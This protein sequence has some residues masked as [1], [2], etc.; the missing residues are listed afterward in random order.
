M[1]VIMVQVS[2]VFVR[3]LLTKSSTLPAVSISKCTHVTVLLK[4]GL[5][6]TTENPCFGVPNLTRDTPSL[7]S[8]HCLKFQNAHVFGGDNKMALYQ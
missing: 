5:I 8:Q 7:P 1:R 4:L 3:K 2:K 6:R